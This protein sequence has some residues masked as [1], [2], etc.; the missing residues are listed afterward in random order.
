M[1]NH[2]NLIKTSTTVNHFIK[3]FV[4]FDIG[5]IVA[6]TSK[7]YVNANCVTFAENMA[8]APNN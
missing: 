1:T 4:L 8:D 6:P 2:E 3:Q 7:Y 5:T